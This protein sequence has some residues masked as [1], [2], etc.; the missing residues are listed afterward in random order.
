MKE[1]K[2]YRISPDGYIVCKFLGIYQESH[3]N[4]IMYMMKIVS[5]D[6]KSRMK[7][8]ATHNLSANYNWVEL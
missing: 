3:C 5:A 6:K 4:D 7:I 8:G 2:L 1:G